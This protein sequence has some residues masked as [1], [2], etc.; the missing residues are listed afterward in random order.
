MAPET[1]EASKDQ[2]WQ[3]VEEQLAQQAS[4]SAILH[5][6]LELSVLQNTKDILATELTSW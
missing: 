2:K 6:K 3:K 1:R 4:Q 5:E